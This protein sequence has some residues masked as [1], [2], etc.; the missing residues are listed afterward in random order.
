V[1]SCTR[2][3]YCRAEEGGAPYPAVA[4]LD[5]SRPLH[6]GGFDV[7]GA[8]GTCV[9]ASV[10]GGVGERGRETLTMIGLCGTP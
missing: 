6:D 2:P 10:R 4:G 7:L 8:Y 3:V 1:A 9:D 5:E